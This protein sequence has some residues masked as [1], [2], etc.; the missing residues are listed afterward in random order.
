MSESSAPSV[1]DD[2][3]ADFRHPI[4]LVR[5]AEG[6]RPPRVTA[7]RATA[8][9]AIAGHGPML[10]FSQT[11]PVPA[12]HGDNHG[13]DQAMSTIETH[14]FDVS[15]RGPDPMTCGSSSFQGLY[16]DPQAWYPRR[17]GVEEGG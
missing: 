13:P 17:V 14:F 4:W 9:A 1:R 12:H 6:D 8:S 5:E 3:A 15:D 11:G 10:Q 2:L 16:R 7:H